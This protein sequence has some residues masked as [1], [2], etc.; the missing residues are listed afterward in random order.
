MYVNRSLL[1][2]VTVNVAPEMVADAE[3]KCFDHLTSKHP[4]IADFDIIERSRVFIHSIN[5][6][7]ICYQLRRT[8][9][10]VFRGKCPTWEEL[11]KPFVPSTSSQYNFSRGGLGAVGAFLNNER[12]MTYEKKVS[13]ISKSLGPVTLK[14]ELTEL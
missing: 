1:A 11:T 9:R 3:Q 6:H 8:V 5:R 7:T 14:K 2:V 4:D 10:E 12:I 13:F